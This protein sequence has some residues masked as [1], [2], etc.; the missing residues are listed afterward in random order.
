MSKK[1]KRSKQPRSLTHRSWGSYQ[2]QTRLVDRICYA[3][4]QMR[5]GDFAGCISTCEPLLDLLPKHSEMRLNM[6]GLMGLAH[7]MLQNYHES[8]AILGE[9]LALDPTKAE[10]W[11]NHGQAAYC[12]GRLSETVRDFERAVELTKHDASEKAHKFASQLRE[13]RQELQ[14][15]MQLHGDITLEEYTAREERFAQAV[16]LMKQEKWP[17]AEQMFR[18]LAETGARFAPYWGNLGVCLTVQRR[19]D[20][21]EAALK[22]SLAIDP[23]YPFAR[24]NLKRLPAVRRSKEPVG[25]RTLNLAQGDDV[26]HSL[27]LYEEGEATA[28][29]IIEKVGR[30]A[31]GIWKPTGKQSPRYDF[32]L[33]TSSDTRFT[34]CPRCKG[35]TQ[36]RKFCLVMNVHP[37]IPVILE[38]TCRYCDPCN[39]LI[40]HRDQ[41]DEQVAKHLMTSNPQAVDN[42]YL[43]VGTLDKA[44]W[45]HMKHQELSFEDIIE[46]LHDFKDVV[47]FPR[48]SLEG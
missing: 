17:E 6:L 37:N 20:E 39:L 5:A 36:A 33:N 9:A 21:A 30:A 15:S 22:Q 27:A 14:R 48:R 11:H 41:L 40:V 38:K 16:R 29:T 35:K 13:S 28:T 47:T 44:V 31:T 2:I 3:E 23:D 8:Y 45:N 32:F 26:T 46:D 4:E 18:Q 1:S 34:T 7:G 24:D 43:V 10:Y 19:Y 25:I 42:D 12:L